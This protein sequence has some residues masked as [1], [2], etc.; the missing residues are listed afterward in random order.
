MREPLLLVLDW[1]LIVI[2]NRAGVHD[3]SC[4][5]QCKTY[6]EFSVENSGFRR[7]MLEVD[8]R[9]CVLIDNLDDT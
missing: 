7:S 1:Q 4:I 2:Q 8:T 9:N 5:Y 3:S 6:A